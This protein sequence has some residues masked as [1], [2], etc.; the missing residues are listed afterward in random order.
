MTGVIDLYG[1]SLFI[2]SRFAALFSDPKG[3]LLGVLYCLPAVLIALSFHEW[4]HAYAAYRLGDPTARNLGRMTVNPM[5]HLDPIGILMLT[6][7]GFG[8]ARPVPINPR[9]FSNPRRDELIVSCA[10]VAA[11][12][13]LA[14]IFTGIYL[15]VTLIIGFANE[16]FMT[17]VSYIITLNISLCIFNL[18]PIPP[19]DGF[20]VLTCI[21]PRSGGRFFVFLE[22]YGF[23]ILIAL[24]FTGVVT[25]VLTVGVTGISRG[26]TWLWLKFF[27]LFS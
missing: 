8:W 1:I 24:L 18:I 23:L 19:L 14:F 22:R 12:L 17:I 11:N 16:I 21:F 6:F 27:S 15:L 26:M 2:G 7:I 3:F 4:A 13:A 25:D 9:N 20:H 10:G 5:A